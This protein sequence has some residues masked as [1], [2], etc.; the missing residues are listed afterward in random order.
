MQRSRTEKIQVTTDK[1][2]SKTENRNANN[3]CIYA[4]KQKSNKLQ[5][6]N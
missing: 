3:H 5:K 6:N 4:A 1:L 2:C